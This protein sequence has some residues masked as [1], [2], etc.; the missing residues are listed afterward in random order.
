MKKNIQQVCILLLACLMSTTF[1]YS[2]LCD[3]TKE[4]FPFSA[5]FNVGGSSK[6]SS[7][8]FQVS[9]TIGNTLIGS[10]R[11]PNVQP[12]SMSTELGFWSY[13]ML[14]P[15]TPVVHAS[16][17]DFPDR[18][19]VRW[20][21]IR[22]PFGPPVIEQK[23]YRDGQFLG[24]FS[25][26]QNAYLDF[27]VLPGQSYRYD[28]VTTNRFG[29]SIA[30][31]DVGFVN[32]N[33]V[34]TGTVQTQSFL[35]VPDVEVVLTPTIAYALRFNGVG[36]KITLTDSSINNVSVGTFEFWL[37]PSKLT[38]ATIFSKRRVIA[39]SVHP[40]NLYSLISIGSYP[41]ENGNSVDGVPGRVYF[42]PKN[43]VSPLWSKRNLTIQTWTHVAIIFDSTRAAIYI[44]GIFDNEVLGD[45]RIPDDHSPRDARNVRTYVGYWEGVGNYYEGYLDEFRV[46]NI[47]RTNEQLL[48]DKDRTVDADA[49]NLLMYWK[50][51]EGK[52]TRAYD[53][54]GGL[55]HGLF[56]SSIEFSN[57]NRAPVYTSGI[58]NEQGNY[59]IKGI[60]YGSGT[61]FAAQPRKISVI[62]RALEF[63]G[64][65]D[66]VEIPS[67]IG[68]SSMTSG[69][70][71]AWVYPKSNTTSQP[72]VT[73][74]NNG[75]SF[76]HTLSIENGNLRFQGANGAVATDA[77]QLDTAFWYH[78]AVKFNAT[79]VTFYLNG[80]LG[81]IVSGNFSLSA[82]N[83]TTKATI[84]NL[85]NSFFFGRIDE[86]RI[87]NTQRTQ[88]Q[89]QQ[90]M[91]APFTTDEEGMEA[92]WKLNEGGGFA[93]ADE[94]PNLNV[95]NILNA[96]S[97]IWT[98][99][100]PMNETFAHIF[101][102]ESRDVTLAPSNTVV[103][104]IDYSDISLI[105]V[106]GFVKYIGTSCFA[107]SV[108]VMVDGAPV[109]PAVYTASDGKF[110]VE[111]EP[112]TNHRL[113]F[114][115][116]THS[117]APAF[118]EVLNVSQPIFIKFP[119]MDTQTRELE[120]YV[121][122]GL[123]KAPIGISEV[124]LQS[125]NGCYEQVVQTD[126]FG[127]F[128]FTDVPPIGYNVFVKHPDP[129]ITFDGEQINLVDN[130]DS[131]QFVY[132]SSLLATILDLPTNDC[133][134][135][136]IEKG[137]KKRVKYKIYESYTD[138]S[139][140]TECLMPNGQVV[141]I[142]KIGNIER[143][144]TLTVVNGFV[145]DTIKG[146]TPNVLAGGSHPY[147]KQLQII[148]I[149]DLG[150]QAIKEEWIYVLGQKPRGSTFATRTPEIP[151]WILHDP[152]GDAS[153]SYV[154]TDKS[155]STAVSFSME[156]SNSSGG[157]VAVHLGPDITTSF[158]FGAETEFEVDATI[159]FTA[160]T[161]VSVTQSSS[162]EQTW[163]FTSSETFQ[164]SDGDA[165][166]GDEGDVYI[167]GA[168]NM[169]YGI[170]DV[171]KMDSLCVPY[172]TS[173]L[174]L[175]PD[176]FATTF[177]YSESNIINNVIPSLYLIGDTVS[178]LRWQ[179]IVDKNHANKTAASF[180]RNISFDAGTTY[181]NSET[182]ERSTTSTVESSMLISNDI[183]VALGLTVNGIGV[184]GGFNV[185]TEYS[186]GSSTSN[187]ESN[188]QTFG[189]VL[190]DDD[191]GDYFSV[192]VRKDPV[193]GTPV[194][195]LVSGATSC[196]LEPNTLAREGVQIGI[197]PAA[198]VN[199][200]PDQPATFSLLVG[201]ASPSGED[202]TYQITVPQA[203]NPDGAVIKVNG[204][205][206]ETALLIDIPAGQQVPVTLTVERGPLAYTY[207]DLQVKLSSTCDGAIADVATFSVNFEVPCSEVKMS[208]PSN[209][210]LISCEDPDSIYVTLHGYD[211][212]NPDFQELKFQY[213]VVPSSLNTF[214]VL[215]DGNKLFVNPE[216]FQKVGTPIKPPIENIV[217]SNGT[218][219]G[220]LDNPWINAQVIP[221]D[222]LPTAQNYITFIW[223]IT[224]DI[225]PD[226][227]YEIRAIS[228]CAAQTINGSSGII[229]GRIDRTPPALLGSTEPVDGVLGQDDQ[230][231]AHFD[232]NIDCA[233]L[234][235]LLNVKL[236]NSGT[237]LQ[238]DKT[239]TCN[240]NTVV[241]TPTVPNR[242]LENQVLRLSFEDDGSAPAYGVRDVY[243]NRITRNLDY[244]FYVDRN[245][246]RWNDPTFQTTENQ[247]QSISFTRRVMNSGAFAQNYTISG[248]P[249]WLSASPIN[250]SIPAGFSQ[251]VVFT[252]SPQLSGGF[253]KDTIFAST[254][255][256][257]E[258]LQLDFRILCPSPLWSVDETQYQY[259]M[260]IDGILKIDGVTATDEY[261][262]IAAF[263]GDEVRG[264]GDV[265]YV[266]GA[267][268]TCK[269]QVFLTV[270]SNHPRGEQLSFKVWDA[271]TCRELGT[272]QESYTF[273][274][275][276]VYGRPDKPATFTASSQVVQQ[277]QLAPGWT[278]FSL[279]L[280]ADNMSVNTL[281]NKVTPH[282]ND[283][284][285]GQSS[286]SQYASGLGWVGTLTTL[287]NRSMYQM[288]LAN[289]DTIEMSGYP[290]NLSTSK[291]PVVPGWNWIAYQPQTG[292]EINY[293]LGRL[294]PLN[295]N[296]IKNQSSYAIYV[297]GLGWVGSLTFLN[298]RSGYLLKS[299]SVDSLMYPLQQQ[300]AKTSPH[301]EDILTNEPITF[302]NWSVN[303]AEYLYSM[304]VT[305]I[306]EKDNIVIT[307]SLDRIGAFVGDECRG[308]ARAI[309]V[310][311]L[312]RYFIFMLVYSDIQTGENIQFRFMDASTQT[313]YA[314][315]EN[316][317]FKK[318]AILG[319][320][321]T[322]YSLKTSYVLTEHGKE[323]LPKEFNLSQN[324]P[325]PFNPS[326]VI[327]YSL[328][329]NS[330]VTLKVY[331]VLGREIITLVE[332]LQDAGYKSV[333]WDGTKNNG[334][335]V[336]GG[337]YFYKL[338]AGDFSSTKKLLL[339][340]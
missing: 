125:V 142:D 264:V 32:P 36:D 153:Y 313:T 106:V 113:T 200:P 239:V 330:W 160:T 290:V 108:E 301:E 211:R 244:E 109:R 31:T 86:V 14:E 233:A 130:N 307:D 234:H 169:L 78:V 287:T 256:G 254:A 68:G 188:V 206:I 189:Y 38:Q 87:W 238:I 51:D 249:T 161:S 315:K 263:A 214:G 194:F 278:W 334:L 322:P 319:E 121:V 195:Q 61:T 89:I 222:S 53:L 154:S 145:S 37:N 262:R 196:P 96:D 148:G 42:Q 332:G 243:G 212:L 207:N 321:T 74:R 7:N 147:Q 151:Y 9:L 241:V 316:I 298:P 173:D 248:L 294:H 297:A 97:T 57:I 19:E 292:Y 73:L 85:S 240:G 201:N 15:N 164:T 10:F 205:A 58:T 138:G 182:T 324:Y 227:I 251:D 329:V 327:D 269:Y 110:K 304:A 285:K 185:A 218:I 135:N 276:T 308:I 291:I 76:S 252:I 259:S 165:V 132:R 49:P 20:D 136:V 12:G 225:V 29:N 333:I 62:G 2:Q 99:F 114:R 280:T 293:A 50:F 59:I 162:K 257:D 25:P 156:N 242:F 155:M 137:K 102:P 210:W 339:L 30:G 215:I 166:I 46:W 337:I 159:D 66:A 69:T 144:D 4:L 112:G 119:I 168:M 283:I 126:A 26:T 63:D 310:K 67:S 140:V 34:I 167:G 271:V 336:S 131:V 129:T 221:K 124:T 33:G 203:S 208:S 16:D 275:D 177:M 157:F 24:V 43:G 163:T 81:S 56:C 186:T 209:N 286:F 95:G 282:S 72:I 219:T 98:K 180:I 223:L 45:F 246:M 104:R 187:S 174:L 55:N 295:G 149:D 82:G 311:G 116:G 48:A 92:Y 230:I 317:L 274:A 44:N 22:D 325:N 318:D 143:R 179:A 299:S 247:G 255:N 331:D 258:D 146:G 21:P 335:Q 90:Y 305:G 226:G 245:S 340:K 289:R 288:K 158:G 52:G 170:A 83:E 105:P 107:E 231:I 217:Q 120:G 47:N 8:N 326:T 128:E 178:A 253:Y 267:A 235:P 80:E 65:D 197:S 199:V 265:V 123:C 79:E 266:P 216:L 193:Y 272:I 198:V 23:L 64:I 260:N 172:L 273:I 28:V 127:N 84:G 228:T 314:I 60:N 115:K 18:I 152:P 328:P 103:D 236:T 35:P 184:E 306:I 261:D 171:L 302:N 54:S 338:C 5:H 88:Q 77:T 117:F 175:I 118:Y 75:A 139:T 312:N 111:F 122:G 204:V 277:I 220:L 91:N 229:R 176:N 303:P 181:E 1:A 250:A 41:D 3:P 191:A 268:D 134:I 71:E 224:R 202:G 39:D 270:H 27:N 141:V 183:A 70:I 11:N 100:I 237:G 17:G 94:T 190:A 133:N 320:P 93:L 296:L 309:F 150:R 40:N 323:L 281:M 284:I 300:T 13:M 232:E 101:Q 213:R 279:N 6:M 192:N